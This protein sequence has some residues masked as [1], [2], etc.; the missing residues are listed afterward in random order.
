MTNV[1]LK[2]QVLHKTASAIKVTPDDE[3]DAWIPIDALIDTDLDGVG[4]GDYIFIEVT[5]KLA[6]EKGLI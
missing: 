3:T 4:P 2:V 6:T 1:I 5:E